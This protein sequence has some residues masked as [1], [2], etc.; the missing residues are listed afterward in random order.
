[1]KTAIEW[2]EEQIILAEDIYGNDF[3]NLINKAKE[4]ERRQIVE[5]FTNGEVSTLFRNNTLAD[6][7]YSQKFNK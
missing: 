7:Y 2:L 4:M 5:A 6:E 1:M 3:K